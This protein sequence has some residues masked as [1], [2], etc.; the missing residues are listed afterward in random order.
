MPEKWQEALKHWDEWDKSIAGARVNIRN[1]YGNVSK[2]IA[3]AKIE[4]KEE[5]KENGHTNYTFILNDNMQTIWGID[6]E[7][8]KAATDFISREIGLNPG[9]ELHYLFENN[10][11]RSA[12]PEFRHEADVDIEPEIEGYNPLRDITLESKRKKN[13]KVINSISW[14]S[15]HVQPEEVARLL[16]KIKWPFEEHKVI[17]DGKGGRPKKSRELTLYPEA[18]VCYLLKRK[19]KMTHK[20]IADIFWLVQDLKQSAVPRDVGI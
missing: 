16:Q 19:Q 1:K 20:E 4:V 6:D 13:G 18:I 9:S 15:G 10:W 8:M 17:H 7:L 12:F 14:Y 5:R 11:M 3:R 2:L